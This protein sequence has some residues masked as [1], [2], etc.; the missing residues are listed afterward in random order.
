M[1]EQH[2]LERYQS[3]LEMSNTPITVLQIAHQQVDVICQ[4]QHQSLA[5]G[6]DHLVDRY[7]HLGNVTPLAIENAIVAIE[8]QIMTIP[9]KLLSGS[10]LV[11]FDEAIKIIAKLAGITE[12]DEMI[13]DIDSLEWCFNRFADVISGYPATLE[14]L[15]TDPEFAVTLLVLREWMHHLQF[16]SITIKNR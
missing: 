11:T 16:S 8:D 6:I 14:G 13:L 4:A 5:M 2:L 1:N 9:Y 10:S 15:P 12:S 3:L 7:F